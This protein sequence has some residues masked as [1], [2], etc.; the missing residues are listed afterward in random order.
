[1]AGPIALS[2][3]ACCCQLHI[4]ILACDIVSSPHIKSPTGMDDCNVP[5]GF[6]AYYLNTA[7]SVKRNAAVYS[8]VKS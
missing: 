6:A 5:A 1:M 2:R 3:H 4:G 7:W 8:D